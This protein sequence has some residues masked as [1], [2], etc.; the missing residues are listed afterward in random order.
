MSFILFDHFSQHSRLTFLLF[1]SFFSNFSKI[2]FFNKTL[3]R[4]Y[5]LADKSFRIFF[6]FL[7]SFFNKTLKRWYRLADNSFNLAF[8]CSISSFTLIELIITLPLSYFKS[9]IAFSN[10]ALISSLLYCFP[11]I[12]P[13]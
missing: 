10:K 1:L 4:W 3:K 5:R 12:F 11:L 7:I 9:L 6:Y 2:S 8:N 13:S